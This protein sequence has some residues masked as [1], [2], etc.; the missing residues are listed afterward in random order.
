MSLRSILEAAVLWP[1]FNQ[2][3]GVASWRKYESAEVTAMPG[4]RGPE[5]GDLLAIVGETL[6]RLLDRRDIAAL[7]IREPNGGCGW[8]WW[9]AASPWMSFNA[10]RSYPDNEWTF[11]YFEGIVEVSRE[12]LLR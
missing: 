1:E 3:E 5:P 11:E 9:P 4:S 12:E 8:S 2:D 10:P 7:T 6:E